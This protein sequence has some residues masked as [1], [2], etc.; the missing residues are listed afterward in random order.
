MAHDHHHGHH[1]Q[2]G[3]AAH[4]HPDHAGHGDHEELADILDLDAEVL[5]EHL[6]EVMAWVH[7]HAAPATT[8]LDLGAGTG[9]GTLALARRFPAARITAVD[10]SPQML[11]HLRHKAAAVGVQERIKTIEA[12]LD[13]TPSSTLPA[14]DLVWAANS[15]H[16]LADPVATLR[17]IRGAIRPGGHLVALEMEAFPRFLPGDALE[18]RCHAAVA[19][20][21]A[22]DMPHLGADWAPLLRA[23][24]FTVEATRRFE[25]DLR[26]PLPEATVRYAQT[27]LRRLRQG[28]QDRLSPADLTALEALAEE[29]PHRR[30]LV[31]QARRTAWAARP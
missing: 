8:V 16:H 4:G 14:A 28:L 30:D 1:A 24:G 20:A 3:H 5:H 10:V 27:T 18:E 31:V 9:A 19:E 6:T 15:L 22:V 23:A 2:H 11:E 29:V 26:P 12:D 17:G 21:R 13:T 7:E 25:I